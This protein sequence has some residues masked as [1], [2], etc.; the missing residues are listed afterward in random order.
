MPNP[1]KTVYS[2]SYIS[3]QGLVTPR[4]L[5][6]LSSMISPR[7]LGSN[8]QFIQTTMRIIIYPN[9]KSRPADGVDG[10][11]LERRTK[12]TMCDVGV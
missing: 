11:I 2:Y 10:P 1:G 5:S 12:I 9:A 4:M 7:M 6:Y 8:L 3:R